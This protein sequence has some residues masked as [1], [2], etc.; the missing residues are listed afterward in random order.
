VPAGLIEDVAERQFCCAGCRTAY[1]IIH[2]HGLDRYYS[3]SEQRA[4]PVRPTGDSFESFD[5][6]AF[7]A[8]YVETLPSGLRR[9]ELYLEGVHCASCVWLVE[10]VPLILKGVARAELNVRRSLATVEWNPVVVRLSD[11]ARQLDV[12]G[13]TPHPYRGAARNAIRTRED[14]A[15]LARIGIAAAIAINVMLAALALYSG[16]GGGIG[17]EWERYFRWISFIVVT[18]AMIWPARV[19]FAGALASLRV[20]ALSMDVP[21]ALGLA[22]GYIQ[23]A[24]N[25]I[26]D[27]GPVYFD[28]LAVLIFALLVGRYLQMRGQRAAADSAEL[29][30]SLTPSTARVVEDGTIRT[31][32][33]EAL[34]PGAV[35]DVRAGDTIPAD[36]TVESGASALDC[37]L[38]TGESKLVSVAPGDDV[39]AGTVNR[40]GGI[41][42][43][44]TRPG[45]TSR[46]AHLMRQVEESAARRA[47]IVQSANR[48]AGVFV[49]VVLVLATGT[50]IVW[51][52]ID[53]A[54]AVDHAIALL[55]VTCPCAL[56]L[57]T[58]LAVSVAIGRAAR[59]GILVKG[60]DAL[61]ALARPSLVLLDKTG[62]ITEGRATVVR[63]SGPDFVKRVVLA[64]EAQSSHP[65]ADAFARA[66]PGVAAPVAR[67]VRYTAGRGVEGI[68]EGA[69]VVVG[70]PA[71]VLTRAESSGVAS[72]TSEALTTILVA[73]NGVVVAEAEIGDTLRPDAAPAVDALRSRGWR[74][75]VLSGDAQ[76][77]VD[78]VGRALGLPADDCVGDATPEDKLARV[79]AELRSGP[80]V[81][82]GDGVNDAAAMA[83][84]TVGVSVHGGAEASL[85]TA[86]VYLARPGLAPLVELTEGA[87]RTLAVIRRNIAFSI[88]YNIIGAG[89]AMAGMMPPMAAAVL[90][91]ASS[92]TVVFASWRARTFDGGPA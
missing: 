86:D 81:M 27:E 75:G 11:I 21:I 61:E 49:A 82:V 52:A 12:L 71:F 44:V 10:R 57:S 23:G 43:L 80:V 29:L 58:P 67:D 66:W 48:L 40:R 25:T 4:A 28:G 32:P 20:R 59:H 69:R 13:Y 79:Q 2:E 54:R 30:Q 33:S 16:G 64:V 39:F 15:M 53:P 85:R 46:V 91:P 73:V 74:V 92:L 41:R 68:V 77:V 78:A 83:A 55:I 63:W 70:S 89:L 1:A 38:L 22:A 14:R 56:A 65:V 8:L 9:V 47:P 3:L 36:G 51:Q 45:E 31:I 87:Q 37:S 35:V 34:V 24:V 84:A 19:F 62:T 76:P 7:D 88:V 26:A 6:T 17:A 5:H 72:R 42:V 50:W 18:P 60:G 90:M